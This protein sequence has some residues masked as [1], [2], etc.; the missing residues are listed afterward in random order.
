TAIAIG[1]DKY[2]YAW[3]AATAITG[4]AAAVVEPTRVYPSVAG[5]RDQTFRSVAIAR[6]ENTSTSVAAAAVSDNGKLYVWGSGSPDLLLGTSE[7]VQ[8]PTEILMPIGKK[9]LKVFLGLGTTCAQSSYYALYGLVL[10]EDGKVYT[11]G[12]GSSVQNCDFSGWT[13]GAVVKEVSTLSALSFTNVVGWRNNSRAQLGMTILLRQS[14]GDW[15]QWS[16]TKQGT[17]NVPCCSQTWSWKSPSQLGIT[18]SMITYGYFENGSDGGNEGLY[19]IADDGT[20]RFRYVNQT[21]SNEWTMGTPFAVP[22]PGNRTVRQITSSS[23]YGNKL[24]ASDGTMWR[25]S[26]NLVWGKEKINMP[27][28]AL[29]LSRFAG[30][31]SSFLIGNGG[32]LWNYHSWQASQIP[33]SCAVVANNE[34][35]GY[36]EGAT[37]VVSSGQFG[38]AFTEDS[39]KNAI[40]SPNY[41]GFAD[42]SGTAGTPTLTNTWDKELAVRPGATVRLYSYFKSSCVGTTGLSMKWDLDDDGVFETDSATSDVTNEATSLVSRYTGTTGEVTWEGIASAEFKQSYIDISADSLG[43]ALSQ[44]GGRFISV[45]YSSAKGSAT[46]RYAIIVRPQ[47][48]TGRVGVTVNAGARFTDSTDVTIGLVWPEGTTTALI[49][50]D[51]SFSDAQEVPVASKVRWSLQSGGAGL[52][53]STVYVRFYGLWA[54]GAGG[55]ASPEQEMAI[56]NYTDDIIL[57]LS[58]PEITSVSASTT[59]SAQ[60]QSLNSARA[61]SAPTAT[62]LVSVTALDAVSGISAVQ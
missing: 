49:S 19:N 34:D 46:Q 43:G 10:D 32:S 45:K 5:D 55:W 8:S 52:L 51:G 60:S 30:S 41:V 1:A 18:S 4:T 40:D 12:G 16:L 15:Y 33:G 14:S 23:D 58:P 57:D 31:N 13:D 20:L 61:F 62:A 47:K 53:S 48:P 35:E 27:I 17:Y 21:N 59:S 37:R 36:S 25:V 50:N 39:F 2:L 28:E 7:S 3:G 54:N 56:Y 26:S 24:I 42:R 9:A 6:R 22:L 29:P 38:P 11:W 44:G